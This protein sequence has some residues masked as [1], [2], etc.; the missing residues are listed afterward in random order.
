[1]QAIAVSIG[2]CSIYTSIAIGINTTGFDYIRQCIVVGVKVNLVDHSILVNIKIIIDAIS[3]AVNK[4]SERRIEE[5][6]KTV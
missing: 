4:T 5:V 1:M 2:K 3:I 6:W